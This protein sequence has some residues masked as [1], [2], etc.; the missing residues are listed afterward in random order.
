MP[1]RKTPRGSNI[2]RPLRVVATE[3]VML[4][5]G[6]SSEVLGELIF[7]GFASIHVFV[8]NTSSSESL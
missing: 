4:L 2:N 6:F 3:G 5:G 1:I 7:M 8:M